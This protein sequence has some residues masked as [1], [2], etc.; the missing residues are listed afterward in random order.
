MVLLL[1]F[2]F[3]L[4]GGDAAKNHGIEQLIQ[5]FRKEPPPE[6]IWMIHEAGHILDETWEPPLQ[7][8]GNVVLQLT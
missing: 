6:S 7:D 8:N 3:T 5:E 2:F 1:S 4:T